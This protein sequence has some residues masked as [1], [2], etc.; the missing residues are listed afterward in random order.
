V[1]ISPAVVSYRAD[2]VAGHGRLLVPVGFPRGD[3]G[4]HFYSDQEVWPD[5]AGDHPE[6]EGRF[7][8]DELA[9]DFDV[10][11]GRPR[12]WLATAGR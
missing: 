11:P 1:I 6:H 2:G 12:R 7:M 9:P 5:Q 10:G 8:G 4:H 3:G